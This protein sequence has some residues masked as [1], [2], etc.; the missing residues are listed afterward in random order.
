MFFLKGGDSKTLMVVQV[1]PALKN[2]GE[3]LCSLNF[4]QRA[5]MVQLGRALKKIEGTG[6][7]TWPPS[8]TKPLMMAAMYAWSGKYATKKTSVFEH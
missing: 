8:L 7:I 6:T 3:T 2:V 1:S 5:R 4:V